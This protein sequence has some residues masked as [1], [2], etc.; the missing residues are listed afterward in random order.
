[1]RDVAEMRGR[2][3]RHRID[4]TTGK[5]AVFVVGEP[6]WHGLGTVID[7][8]VTSQEAIRLAGLD[9]TVEK[10][11]LK[12]YQP[13]NLGTVDVRGWYATVRTDTKAVL[14][15]VSRQYR[16]LQNTEA[17]AFMDEAIQAGAAMWET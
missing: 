2:V 13:E 3:R 8:A 1:M 14:G 7:A 10:W 9:W 12:A 16:V 11:P 6:P 4:Q 15:V 17:F 5:A